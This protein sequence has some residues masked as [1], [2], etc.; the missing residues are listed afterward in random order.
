MG[1]RLTRDGPPPQVVTHVAVGRVDRPRD[2]IDELGADCVR[3]PLDVRLLLGDLALLPEVCGTRKSR[4]A[5]H[6][7][8][9]VWLA[10]T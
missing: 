10:R 6:A 9:S 5:P 3:E 7:R 1:E 2:G 8:N 4:L